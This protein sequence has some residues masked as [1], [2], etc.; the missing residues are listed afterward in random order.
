MIPSRLLGQAGGKW[1]RTG[2]VEGNYCITYH[3]DGVPG[4]ER[5][6]VGTGDDAGAEGLHGPL[7]VVDDV[8][9]VQ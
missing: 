7:G 5:E 8:E 9:G 4:G 3:R 2:R 6:D 1:R